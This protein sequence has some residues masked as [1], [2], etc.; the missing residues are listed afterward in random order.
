MGWELL[1][2]IVVALIVGAIFYYGFKF[3]GPW[4][5][6]WAFL[7]VLIIGIWF[8]AALAEP[9]GPIWWGIAWFDLFLFAVLFAILLIAATPTIEDR[10]RHRDYYRSIKTDE[11]ARDTAVTVG[12]WF[13]VM[14]ILF[15]MVAIIAALAQ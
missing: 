5:T 14:I 4:G 7:L 12:V 8:M 3:T 6:F 2:A 9:I 13:W 11:E 15:L 1:G 10:R